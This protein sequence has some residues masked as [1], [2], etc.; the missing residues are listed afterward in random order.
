MNSRWTTF[1]HRCVPEVTGPEWLRTDRI[2]FFLNVTFVIKTVQTDLEKTVGDTVREKTMHRA[3]N[4]PFAVFSVKADDATDV[5]RIAQMSIIVC[6]AACLA[7]KLNMPIVR[8]DYV[9]LVASLK[10]AWQWFG[11]Q[12]KRS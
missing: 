2:F 6:C 12:N 7:N 5:L 1:L 9:E 4:W 3:I 10:L 11:R 8:G